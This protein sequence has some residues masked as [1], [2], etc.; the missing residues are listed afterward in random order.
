MPIPTSYLSDAN[1]PTYHPSPQIPYYGIQPGSTQVSG[2]TTIPTTAT[3]RVATYMPSHASSQASSL[4]SMSHTSNPTSNP[5]SFSYSVNV[6]S[7]S[8]VLSAGTTSAAAI[9]TTSASVVPTIPTSSSYSLSQPHHH[10]PLAPSVSTNQNFSTN[11][12]MNSSSSGDSTVVKQ[13][14]TSDGRNLNGSVKPIGLQPVQPIASSIASSIKFVL[15]SNR[16]SNAVTTSSAPLSSEGSATNRLLNDSPLKKK[17][18]AKLTKA[19][20]KQILKQ[21]SMVDSNGN[22]C[23]YSSATSVNSVSMSTG[24]ANGEEQFASGKWPIPLKEYA[25]RA[26]DQC[27]N[28]Q[29]KQSLQ[30]TLKQKLTLAY[31][32]NSIWTTDWAH[33]PL[34]RLSPES[35]STGAGRASSKKYGGNSDSSPE[36]SSYSVKKRKHRSSRHSESDTYSS[37]GS[38]GSDDDRARPAVASIASRLKSVGKSKKS[39]KLQLASSLGKVSVK[40]FCHQ[41]EDCSEEAAARRRARFDGDSAVSVGLKAMFESEEGIE[42]N[43][44][45]PIVGTNQALEKRYLRLT[46]APDPSSVRPVQVLRKSLDHVKQ[47]WLEKQDYFYICDQLKSIRQDLTVQCV[48]DEFTV[49]VYETHARIALEKVRA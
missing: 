30:R 28:E 8:H 7:S 43:Q 37:Y 17:K 47:R 46:S 22:N 4:H 45:Q 5:S 20:K 32:N 19:Q 31:Q 2:M 33:E 13:T 24:A 6:T 35:H 27:R 18:P 48:R 1:Q 16:L 34:P 29:D 42:L 15:P 14:V 21:Q 11:Q 10:Q 49:Y 40:A 26:F 12:S 36:A 41:S 44:A 23:A 25:K 9:A 39:R 38:D 3:S